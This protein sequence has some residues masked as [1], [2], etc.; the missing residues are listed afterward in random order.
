LPRG[1]VA[2][3]DLAGL[4]RGVDPRDES[5]R[6]T[7]GCAMGEVMLRTLATLGRLRRVG[8]LIGATTTVL[9]FGNGTARP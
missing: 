1:G 7:A 4:G 2:D 5:H 9:H 8:E 3:D 6:R